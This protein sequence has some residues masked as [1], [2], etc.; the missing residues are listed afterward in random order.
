MRF[1]DKFIPISMINC[2]IKK[3]LNNCQ[4]LLDVTWY[5]TDLHNAIGV[6]E[7]Y[8]CTFKIIVSQKKHTDNTYSMFCTSI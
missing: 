6:H 7:K 1:C 8:I 5:A 4:Y 3:L 2:S